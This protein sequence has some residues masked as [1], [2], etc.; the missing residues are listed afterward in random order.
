MSHPPISDPIHA[1]GSTSLLYSLQALSRASIKAN[2][3]SN[4]FRS[5]IIYRH[6][7]VSR[8]AHGL[9]LSSHSSSMS[10][11]SLI[12]ESSY[13]A[14]HFPSYRMVSFI[15]LY[16]YSSSAIRCA[17]S[18][19]SVMICFSISLR[20]RFA[21]SARKDTNNK[22]GGAFFVACVPHAGVMQPLAGLLGTRGCHL[23]TDMEDLT[24]FGDARRPLGFA[25]RS[26]E[27]CAI[28]EICATT[29]HSPQAGLSVI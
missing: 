15:L 14:T 7:S 27:I 6:S 29:H 12:S 10:K 20:L 8:T 18:N 1:S 22:N 28:P 19:G 23:A 24:G 2:W 3:M 11:K 21:V 16:I 4:S 26:A 17:M 25:G 9:P 5:S 13:H